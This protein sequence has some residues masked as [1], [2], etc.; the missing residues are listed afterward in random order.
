MEIREIA[1]PYIEKLS[2]ECNKTVNLAILDGHEMVYIERVRVPGLRN[3]NISIGNRIPVWN[4]AVGKA[5]LAH[6][7]KEPLNE[8]IR[9]LKGLHECNISVRKLMKELDKVRKNGYAEH[10]QE[11]LRGVRAVA[12][13]VFSP[14][15]VTCAI[16]IVVEPEEVSMIEL[17]NIFAPKLIKLGKELSEALGFQPEFVRGRD[18]G[19]I[20]SNNLPRRLSESVNGRM[21]T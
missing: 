10:D 19:A 9:E 4:T 14:N 8:I 20:P 6:L 13:P 7:E 1:R 15:G 21:E 2:R 3:F 16:N 5:L 12:V 17:R 18:Q 11:F